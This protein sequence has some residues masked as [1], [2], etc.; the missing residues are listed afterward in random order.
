M[1]ALFGKKFWDNVIM[2]FTHWAYNE[3]SL[4]KRNFTGNCFPWTIAALGLNLK[5]TWCYIK[6]RDVTWL[7]NL[8]FFTLKL[9][10][11]L[12]LKHQIYQFNISLD[13][14]DILVKFL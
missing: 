8:V 3:D 6:V 2:E 7:S 13:F 9:V 10:F 14:E 11:K 12:L 4:K 5:A 1:E